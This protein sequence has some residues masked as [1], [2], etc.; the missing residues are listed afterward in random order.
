MNNLIQHPIT[1]ALGW[2]MIH[3]L[4]Q[5]T[6]LVI[7]YRGLIM[8][9]HLRKAPIRYALGMGILGLSIVL[10]S[11]TFYQVYEPP[12]VVELAQHSAEIAVPVKVLDDV[13]TSL[14]LSNRENEVSTLVEP[15]F[16]EK[17]KGFLSQLEPFIA[18]LAL[19]WMLG[20]LFMGMK[21]GGSWMY[22]RN[23]R[24]EGLT[25]VD[26]DWE[27]TFQQWVNRMGIKR[28]VQLRYSPRVSEPLTLGHLKPLVL[29]PLGLLS[30]QD[31]QQIEAL[32][33]HELAH[34]RR[35]DFAFNIVQSWVEI[36]FFYHPAIW[37]ISR[38]VRESREHCCDDAAIALSNNPLAYAQALTQLQLSSFQP[39][40]TQLTMSASG[41]TSKFTQR[42]YRIMG[43]PTQN[44]ASTKGNLVAIL[45]FLGTFFLAFQQQQFQ[46]EQA[47]LDTLM[48]NEQVDTQTL[49]NWLLFT[50]HPDTD[51]EELDTWIAEIGKLSSHPFELKFKTGQGTIRELA[52]FKNENGQVRPG[53]KVKF[54]PEFKG[55]EKAMLVYDPILDK[56]YMHL[57]QDQNGILHF[58]DL[59]TQAFGI[60]GG[61]SLPFGQVY[62]EDGSVLPLFSFQEQAIDQ[63]PEDRFTIEL[64]PQTT[65]D[66]L[67]GW[68]IA[69]SK[70]GMKLEYKEISFD[71]ETGELVK[72]SGIYQNAVGKTMPF[73][74]E[75]FDFVMFDVNRNS[76]TI[77][78]ALM[79]KID[80]SESSS[81]PTNLGDQTHIA[82]FKVNKA[83]SDQDLQQI[84]RSLAAL[85]VQFELDHTA[86][87][88]N[89]QLSEIFGRFIYENKS[90]RLI[91]IDQL[92]EFAIQVYDR[93]EDPVQLVLE[94][95][96]FG[97]QI[98]SPKP[99]KDVSE[100]GTTHIFTRRLNT[101]KGPD[102]FKEYG[103][104]KMW[105][106]SSEAIFQAE[107][108][109]FEQGLTS[110]TLLYLN[111]KQIDAEEFRQLALPVDS[112]KKFFYRDPIAAKLELGK[113]LFGPVYQVNTFSPIK[114]NFLSKELRPISPKSPLDTPKAPIIVLDG[115]IISR[116]G[117]MEK[118]SPEAF[119]EQLGIDSE[120][121]ETINVI[122]GEAAINKYG[123]FEGINGVIEIRTK[124]PS[125][126]EGAEE[127]Q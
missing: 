77:P 32:L 99:L 49:Q 31:P 7:C 28:P 103:V 79:A 33:L 110:S 43:Q 80:S 8:L 125:G 50:I 87:N 107:Y 62:E 20:I 11:I 5:I 123:S 65:M 40:K 127:K 44:L 112:V 48:E 96:T 118:L 4:W 74:Y 69:C 27:K 109:K 10:S 24:K 75:H 64:T 30:Q 60:L 46:E 58:Y 41:N 61:E 106:G 114:E 71:S 97:S 68:S 1:E 45:A 91:Q 86:R 100:K 81:T 113:N 59:A 117:P 9:P 26:T 63:L 94:E 6:L 89:K 124:D 85:G 57:T 39:S 92:N 90:Y 3:S 53:W 67:L 2:T 29:I 35:Y 126:L 76:Q 42:I 66:E 88:V 104:S 120:D 70:L 19:G 15:S 73:D 51:Q 55:L 17:W 115:K 37:W 105:Y 38:E 36:L 21:F 13:E 54:A 78:S 47:M 22:L 83:S 108:E 16:Q 56:M 18:P 111:N 116:P 119:K 34:I 12:L 121:I 93:E 102:I 82:S 98:L 101:K 84:Q 23:L 25:S 72:L 95:E 52:A 14:I 122:K